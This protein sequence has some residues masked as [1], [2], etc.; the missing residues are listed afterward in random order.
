MLQILAK[1]NADGQT[2]YRLFDVLTRITIVLIVGCGVSLFFARRSAAFRHGWWLAVLF[3]VVAVPVAAV[4]LPNWGPANPLLSRIAVS[5]PEPQIETL[6]EIERPTTSEFESGIPFV[7][8]PRSREARRS[9]KLQSPA[10]SAAQ[11]P[12]PVIESI[13]TTTSAVVVSAVEDEPIGY[14]VWLAIAWSIGFMVILTQIFLG[15][16]RMTRILKGARRITEEDWH[17]LTDYAMSRLGF[18]RDISLCESTREIGPLTGGWLRPFVL[19]PQG[20][21]VW[22][23]ELRRVVL[24]H[25]LAHAKR[26]D[27]LSLWC[28]RLVGAVLWFHPL[29]WLVIRQLRIERERACDDL[30]LAAGTRPSNYSQHLVEIA[31][32]YRCPNWIAAT[33][34]TMAGRS[35]LEDRVRYVLDETRNRRGM[36]TRA[37]IAAVGL[38]V[39]LAST[40]ATV[41]QVIVRDAAE[42]TVATLEV[43]DGGSVSIDPD[44]SGKKTSKKKVNVKGHVSANGKLVAWAQWSQLG[45]S[46]L[47][48]NVSSATSLPQSWDIKT[49]KNVFWS[50]DL[51]SQSFGSPV[52]ADGKIFIG[53][54]NANGNVERYPKNVDLGCLVCFD[55]TS[56]R[57]LWQHSNEKL[58]TG[59]V[60]DWPLQGISSTPVVDGQRLYYVTNRAVVACLDVNGFR[61][62]KNDGPVQGEIVAND[63]AD[64]VWQYDMIKELGISPKN[65]SGC[66][67]TTDGERLYVTTSNGTDHTQVNVPN[68]NAPDFICLDLKTGKLLWSAKAAFAAR[69][70]QWAGPAVGQIGGRTHVVCPGSDGWLYGFDPEGANGKAK[71]LWKFDCNPK[72]ADF[73]FLGASQKNLQVSMPVIHNGLVYVS[74]GLTPETCPP[75]R[76]HGG[77][78]GDLWCIDPGRG[79]HGLDISEF[80][81]TD[82]NG[83]SVAR[84]GANYDKDK[85]DM[86][87]PNPDSRVVWHYTSE[88]QDGD[89]KI[90]DSEKFHRTWTTGP[91]IKDGLLIAADFSGYVHCLDAV[92]GK[93]HWTYDLFAACWAS[94]LVAD[95]RIFIGDED[96]K[97]VIMEH[98][99]TLNVLGEVDCGRAIYSTPIAV[100]KTLY[101]GTSKKLLALRQTL[102]ST[103]QND[104]S[105]TK[106]WQSPRP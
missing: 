71:L 53:T 10:L 77:D 25:E 58:A 41:G 4:T 14:G 106:P 34:M 56:G 100:G 94:P 67:P 65:I 92:S 59:R 16:T 99:K 90:N 89:G 75:T 6:S 63:E 19:L 37:A 33:A 11:V 102:Q 45:G 103:V 61:D 84:V 55:A 81:T 23:E 40:V 50:A 18:G 7:S 38:S 86:I 36:T 52:V 96:G 9:A 98:S 35:Q 24:L 91:V 15:W 32:A 17:R 83:E 79:S 57:F 54:N 30:V 78:D 43:P 88:D 21:D 93:A 66:S 105:S 39:L 101:V 87:L 47:R 85:G 27:V 28:S 13:E 70:Y 3:A 26:R 29:I 82:K 62:G 80:L 64:V 72:D 2:L 60:H 31:A 74:A 73:A 76:A 95:G 22:P 44:D 20:C 1:L 8:Q 68:P 48:N 51:G 12:R 97:I 69:G 104:K 5:E 49:G 46:S 42:N